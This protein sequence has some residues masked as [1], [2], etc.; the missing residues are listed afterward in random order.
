MREIYK[1]TYGKKGSI[2]VITIRKRTKDNS[3]YFDVGYNSIPL[4]AWDCYG[5]GDDDYDFSREQ[6]F[7]DCNHFTFN[8]VKI[9]T[10]YLLRRVNK[11]QCI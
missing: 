3:G 7:Y 5:D 4:C 2:A 8:I 9:L 1:K 10:F 6:Q 11:V